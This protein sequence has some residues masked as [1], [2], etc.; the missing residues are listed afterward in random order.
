MVSEK[1][2]FHVFPSISLVYMMMPQ[3]VAYLVHTKHIMVSEWIF[4]VVP[5]VSLWELMTTKA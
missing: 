1:K 2:I 5:I 3:G 4:Y